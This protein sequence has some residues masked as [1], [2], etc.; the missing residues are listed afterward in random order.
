MWHP[1]SWA[2][3]AQDML[4]RSGVSAVLECHPAS[5]ESTGPTSAH[6][7]P[8]RNSERQCYRHGPEPSTWALLAMASRL[9]HAA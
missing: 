4:A 9:N 5:E 1:S 7:Q 2:T 6:P 8:F 3:I